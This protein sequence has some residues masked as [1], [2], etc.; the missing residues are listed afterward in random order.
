[1]RIG[2]ALLVQD[3]RL[4]RGVLQDR[5]LQLVN[6]KQHELEHRLV[7]GRRWRA[8]VA[9]PSHKVALEIMGGVHV[10]GHHVRGPEYEND[11]WKQLIATTVG[12]TVLPV[13]WDMIRNHTP[14]LVFHLNAILACRRPEHLR[15]T[16]GRE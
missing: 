12:W 10:S 5:L 9:W 8:D 11:C 6:C 4:F 13:T 1:M 2:K 14:E 3:R 15:Y 16:E 7:P